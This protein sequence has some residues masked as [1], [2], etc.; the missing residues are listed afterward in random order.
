MSQGEDSLAAVEEALSESD[1]PKEFDLPI[2]NMNFKSSVP[3]GEK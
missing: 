2:R 3:L 1:E